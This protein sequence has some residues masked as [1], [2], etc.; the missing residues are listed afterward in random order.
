MIDISH[1]EL[2][3]HKLEWASLWQPMLFR[4]LRRS[5]YKKVNELICMCGATNRRLRQFDSLQ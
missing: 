2:I 5:Q 4:L 3:F 1:D